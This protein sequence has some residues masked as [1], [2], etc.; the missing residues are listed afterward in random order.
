MQ[1][2]DDAEELTRNPSLSTQERVA[3]GMK[4]RL[5]H[6]E[7]SQ[8]LIDETRAARLALASFRLGLLALV[9]FATRNLPWG[10]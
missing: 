2:Q 8:E 1:S 7:K 6:F 5:K 9:V 10:S 3:A 4:I